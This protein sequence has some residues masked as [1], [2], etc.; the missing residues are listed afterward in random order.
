MMRDGETKKL[1]SR[2]IMSARPKFHRSLAVSASFARASFA[3][4]SFACASLGCASVG[5][6]STP[7]S[8]DSKS[9][10]RFTD[11]TAT[12]GIAFTPTSGSSPSS[13]VLEVK[14]SAS[15][16]SL[17]TGLAQL[18]A[19][20]AV[21]QQLQPKTIGLLAIANLSALTDLFGKPSAELL[22]DHFANKEVIALEWPACSRFNA[23]AVCYVTFVPENILQE[24]WPEQNC[25]PILSQK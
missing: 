4:A 11:V 20:L 8:E 9:A 12:S 6:A 23:N 14:A 1:L 13:V 3:R 21:T 25:W 22:G 10:I 19:T 17:K 16:G 18:R 24:W 15:K 7:P 2:F 5:H